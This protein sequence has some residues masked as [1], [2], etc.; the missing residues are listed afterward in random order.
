MRNLT[1]FSDCYGRC[2][3]FAEYQTSRRRTT[4]S[5]IFAYKWY[6]KMYC[7]TRFEKRAPHLPY[8]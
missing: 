4:G 2:G 3:K 1:S 8:A 6:A 7:G 5:G